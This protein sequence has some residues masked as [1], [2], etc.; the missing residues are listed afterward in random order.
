[1]GRNWIIDVLADLHT[2]AA[3]NE[4]PILAGELEKA[5]TVA[6]VE[7]GSSGEDVALAAWGENADSE[8]ILPQAGNG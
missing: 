2:F 5:K 3:R 1:M 8:R 6:V 4:L 7:I